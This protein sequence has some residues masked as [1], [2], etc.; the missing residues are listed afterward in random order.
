[1]REVDV[2]HLYRLDRYGRTWLA[3]DPSPSLVVRQV[4]EAFEGHY[5]LEFVDRDLPNR[6]RG[7]A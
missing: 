7:A 4:R 5:G 3:S 2:T 1:M 6:E